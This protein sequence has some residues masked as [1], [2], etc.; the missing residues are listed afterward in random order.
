LSSIHCP[1]LIIVGEEDRLTPPPL[2]DSMHQ[3]IA[4]SALVTIP[5]A[6]HLASLEQPEAFNAAMVQFLTH[7]V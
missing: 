6:G 1:T 3:A 7:R 5:R 4:G 2:S